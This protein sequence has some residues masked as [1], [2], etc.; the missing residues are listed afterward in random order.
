MALIQTLF[1]ILLTFIYV[2]SNFFHFVSGWSK[3]SLS[4]DASVEHDGY[5]SAEEQMT[6][7]PE[8]EKEDKLV[9][10]HVCFLLFDLKQKSVMF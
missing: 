2:F 5:F 3:G 4:L 1:P 9:H 10:D 8:E 7:D 6:S